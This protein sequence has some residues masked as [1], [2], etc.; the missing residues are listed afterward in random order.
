MDCFFC[1]GELFLELSVFY[2]RNVSI[3]IKSF[4]YFFEGVNV[5]VGLFFFGCCLNKVN[6]VLVGVNFVVVYFYVV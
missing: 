6:R 3:M 2:E 4:W 5:R 1:L